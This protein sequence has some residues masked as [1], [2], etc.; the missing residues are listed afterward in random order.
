MFVHRLGRLQKGG[1]MLLVDTRGLSC[2]QPV[3]MVLNTIKTTDGPLSVLVDN[4]CSLENVSRAAA[5]RGFS[6]ESSPV[7]KM[8]Y[9]EEGL[10]RL[11]LRKSATSAE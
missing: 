9:D 10:T 6:V 3:L 5:N 7:D 11:V 1:I 4:D 8:E 2:P